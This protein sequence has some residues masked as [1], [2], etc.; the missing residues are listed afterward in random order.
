MKYLTEREQI[1]E[2]GKRLMTQRLTT[3]TG[4]NI[5]VFVREENVMLISPSGVPYMETKPEDIV[6]MDLDG[7]VIEGPKKPSSEFAMHSIFYK[8]NPNVNSVV[9]THSDYATAISCLNEDIEPL[10]YIVGSVGDK[11]RCCKYKTFGTYE[12]ANEAYK[13][14]MDNNGIL[15]GNHGV[16]A[17]GSTCAEAFSVA[18]DIEFLAKLKIHSA[19]LG[20]PV[21]LSDDDMVI[22]KEKFK[23]YGQ[24]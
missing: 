4:G 6:V 11:V 21:L 15:L 12:L 1:V 2:F 3:G 17:I 16:L 7:N 5:S 19:T 8:K 9:H 13:T 22:V 14:M 10:H 20:K 18:K 24:Q 23:T